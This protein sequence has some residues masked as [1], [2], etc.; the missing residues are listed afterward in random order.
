MTTMVA[1]PQWLLVLLSV[2]AACAVLEWFF[3]PGVRWYFR[4]KMDRAIEDVNTRFNIE[5][6]QFKLT[7][8]QVLIDRLFHD[9]KVQAAVDAHSRNEGIPRS[10]ALERVDRYAREIVP[11]FNAYA[12]FRIG[13]WIARNYAKW[14]YRVRIGFADNT[15]LSAIKPG[16]SVVFVMNH[17]SNMDYVLV[18]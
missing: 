15:A 12:Y 11:S 3:L 8:R 17:R 16:S 14:L 2:L 4:R 6:P 10:V 9:A 7:R 18:A 1:I 13:Y 5:I